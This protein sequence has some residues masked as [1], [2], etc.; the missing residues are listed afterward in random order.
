MIP[1]S[2]ICHAINNADTPLALMALGAVLTVQSASGTREVPITEFYNPDGMNHM[3][4]APDELLTHVT[5]P[6]C[7]DRSVFIKFTPRRGMDFSL[8]AVAV[9]CDGQGEQTNN[10]TIVVGSVSSS[11]ILLQQPA[12]IIAEQG[13]GDD[14][15]D[16]AT[17]TMR[18]EMGELTNLYGRATYKKQ[19]AKTLVKRALTAVREQ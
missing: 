13:L 4:L 1:S 14:A 16:A 11:P 5:L 2:E 17:E 9:R 19:I 6:R 7:S 18:D 10:V 12:A 15:I 3:A 8:G